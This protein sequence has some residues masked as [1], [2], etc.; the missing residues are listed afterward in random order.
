MRCS[1]LPN[2]DILGAPIGDYLHCSK[3]IAGKCAESRRLLSGLV[4]VAAVDLQVVV[5]LLCMCGSVCRMVHIAKVTPPSLA[6]DA[7][8]YFDVKVKQCFAMCSAINVTDDAWS[9]AQLGPKFGVLGL[10][11]L[12][13]HAAAAFI[14]SLSFS[15]LG[16]ADIIHLQQAVFN[17]QVSLSNAIS[18]NSV[19]DSPFPQKVLSGMIQVQQFHILL[20]SSSPANR[21][22]LLSVAAPHASSW[23]SVV[24]SPGLGL[25]LESNEYQ[26]AIRWWLGLDTSG[27]SMCPFC[28]ATTAL[29]PLGHLAV[30]CRH[31]GDVVICHNL[32]R[33][34]V[35]NLCCH[36]HLSVSVERGH[37]HQRPCPHQAG[38]DRG[39][40]AALDLTITS[41]L[42]SAILSEL[43]LSPGWCRSPCS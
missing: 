36:A 11:S 5:T 37:G 13:H 40:P 3:F 24:P 14:A 34:E 39:K 1:L 10:R 25:H 15:G 2:L 43:C 26:M 9:R 35:F 8:S 20:G 41:P 22:R 19:Q 33:D 23:L 4:D 7:L 18:V 21:A 42:C 28:P 12:S 17:T 16:S 31:G 6:S 30:T 27:Q 32:L 38:W 29:D